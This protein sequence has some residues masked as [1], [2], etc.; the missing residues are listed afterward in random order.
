MNME[1]GRRGR[2]GVGS[3]RCEKLT[4]AFA[5]DHRFEVAG[6]SYCGNAPGR[7]SLA[8]LCRVAGLCTRETGASAERFDG[9]PECAA[10]P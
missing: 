4:R 7:T 9:S 1:P 3:S 5:F 8:A 10:R 2:Q 6:S